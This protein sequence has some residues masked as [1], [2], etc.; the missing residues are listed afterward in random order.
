[1]PLLGFRTLRTSALFQYFRSQ[2]SSCFHVPKLPLTAFFKE[3]TFHT[4]RCRDSFVVLVAVM[5]DNGFLERLF[6]GVDDMGDLP[7]QV[8]CHCLRSVQGI[9]TNRANVML[10]I[11]I[12]FVKN[13]ANIFF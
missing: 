10:D 4:N 6:M 8:F 1:M 3:I 13:L 9:G 12:C 11:P 5:S 2:V 7:V